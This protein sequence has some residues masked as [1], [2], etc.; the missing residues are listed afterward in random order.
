MNLGIKG[1]RALVT[2]ASKGLGKAIALSLIDEGVEVISISRSPI[3][4]KAIHIKCDLNEQVPDLKN[5]KIDIIVNNLGGDVTV[6]NPICTIDEWYKQFH[7]NLGIDIILNNQL[8]PYMQKQKWG[9]I[10]NIS[11]LS[12][13]GSGKASD[14]YASIKSALNTYTIK[15][16]KELAKYGIVVSSVMPSGMIYAGNG[17]DEFKK[18]RQHEYMNYI[19]EK[20]PI[21][22]VGTPEEIA[23][24]VTFLCSQQASYCIGTIVPVTGG[25]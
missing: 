11:S 8:I 16:G 20:M 12:S 24:V 2:G 23:S 13:T 14:S 6:R 25:R 19:R 4:Y 5:Y 18:N 17:W 7:F 21:G 10:V 22:R 9:R 15:L 3:D 1:K